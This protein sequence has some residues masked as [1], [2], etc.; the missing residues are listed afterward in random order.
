MKFTGIIIA[1]LL[2]LLSCDTPTKGNSPTA[3]SANARETKTVKDTMKNEPGWKVLLSGNQCKMKSA[4]YVV[5]ASQLQFD[6]IWNKAFSKEKPSEKPEVDFANHSVIALFLGTVNTGGHSIEI[7]SISGDNV[8]RAEHKLPG[9][10]CIAS[11]A[12]E[13]PYYFALTDAV[14]RGKAEFIISNKEVECE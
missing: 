9:K 14:I 10:T 12:I 13:F 4:L 11:Q 2:I 8:I 3:D 7:S 6:S 5:I 1:G